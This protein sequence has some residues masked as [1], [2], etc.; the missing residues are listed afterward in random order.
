MAVANG[1]SLD[2]AIDYQI[3]EIGGEHDV[4]RREATRT[5]VTLTL[6]GVAGTVVAA[7][8][9]AQTTT[10]IVFLTSANATIGTTGTVDVAATAQIAGAFVIAAGDVGNILDV[11]SGW[12]SVTNAAAGVTGR[13]R[14]S[15]SVY[16]ARVKNPRPPQFP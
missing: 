8:R 4:L 11:V 10:G 1:Q 16:R 6:R 3:D 5:A 14:E 2:H 7:E 12:E 13:N 9:R 15:N